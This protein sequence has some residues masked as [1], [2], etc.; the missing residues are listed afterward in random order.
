MG[1]VKGRNLTDADMTND[2]GGQQRVLMAAAA[3]EAHQ[4]GRRRRGREQRVPETNPAGTT[5]TKGALG[6]PIASSA[7]PKGCARYLAIYARGRALPQM[8]RVGMEGVSRAGQ[9]ASV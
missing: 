9:A 2:G 5:G 3:A 7:I 1:R 4:R 8:V 6:A